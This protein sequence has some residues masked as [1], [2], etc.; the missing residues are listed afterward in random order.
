MAKDW[1]V[2]LD[3]LTLDDMVRLQESA[4]LSMPR[5]LLIL[6][7]IIDR[8]TFKQIINTD[9]QKVM[10]DLLPAIERAVAEWEQMQEVD[11]VLS[12]VA[13]LVEKRFMDTE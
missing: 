2:Y 8:D 12:E 10:K 6:R 7:R 5:F 13:N 4:S 9:F 3:E 11:S 1:Q